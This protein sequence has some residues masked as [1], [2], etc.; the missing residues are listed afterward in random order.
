MMNSQR[1]NVKKV[2]LVEEG[3]KTGINEAIRRSEIINN[4]LKQYV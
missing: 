4:N 2:R 3:K 1:S